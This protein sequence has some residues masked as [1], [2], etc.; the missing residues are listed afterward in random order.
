MRMD[1]RETD[2]NE[3]AAES[4]LRPHVT[5]WRSEVANRVAFLV[6]GEAYF[7]AFRAACLKARHVIRIIGWDIHSRMRLVPGTPDDGLPAELGPFLNALL[8]RR[9][10]LR[11][12]LLIWDFAAIY[13]IEREPLPLLNREWHRHRRLRLRFAADHP[14]GASHH[15]KIV[16]IDDAVAF[17]GGIDLTMRRWDS[18][19]HRPHDLRR[20]DP[21]GEPY[22]PFHDVQALVD[23]PAAA[24]LG[25]L[26]RERWHRAVGRPISATSASGDPWPDDVVPELRHVDVA[27]ARTEPAQDGQPERRE[28]EQLWLRAIA[29]ARH[30]LYIENQFLTSSVIGDALAERLGDPEGPDIV[31]VLPRHCHGWLEQTALADC[32]ARLI[33]RLSAADCYGR[34]WLAYPVVAEDSWV[35]I[36]AKVL[37]VDD[38]LV[39]VGSSNLSNRSMGVDTECDIAI[40]AADEATRS[41]IAD[42][43]HRLLAEH[44]D[45]PPAAIAAAVRGH[46]LI[47]AIERLARGE[48]RLARIEPAEDG[49]PLALGIDTDGVADANVF[50]PERPIQP[51][52]FLDDFLPEAPPRRELW[53][54]ITSS[55][56]VALFFAALVAVWRFTPL[57][58]VV[59]LP[60][61]V[62]EIRALSDRPWLPLY[63]LLAFLFGGF[64]MIP[65]TL[66]IAAVGVAFGPLLGFTYAALGAYSSAAVGF[67]IGRTLGREPVRRLAGP[68]LNRISRRLARSGIVAVTLL[69]LLPIAPFTLVN[70]VAGAMQLRFRDF[71]AGT[72]LGML[73]GIVMMTL[74]GVS[75]ERVLLRG[76]AAS[77]IGLVTVFLVLGGLGYALQRWFG[78]DREHHR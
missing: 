56:T 28:V 73:P 21:D 49:D 3:A 53:W 1:M 52:R 31:L 24:A 75:A 70:V 5:H 4:V 47:G 71:F 37:I 66:L 50:D 22:D 20:I 74:L 36:H 60:V 41:G 77:I 40:E 7:A 39:R 69:R 43:R 54:R 61:L 45:A 72:V 26:A 78:V 63:V 59:T 38:R 51:D 67:V 18:A 14:V 68:R 65:V 62:G 23:G 6:D 64:L 32:Q 44:L 58:H 30:S 15:Q 33:R 11:I 35:R 9:R 29:A 10:R 76:D 2:I 34:L 42:F 12:D 17:V 16:V 8:H 46:G 13:S 48:R 57:N 27:I 25:V 55:V 19:E